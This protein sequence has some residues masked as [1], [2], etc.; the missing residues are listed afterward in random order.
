LGHRISF[1]WEAIAP[2]AEYYRK[3]WGLKFLWVNYEWMAQ[4]AKGY[5][6]KRERELSEKTK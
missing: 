3:T 2:A 5:L 6:E 1:D 4:E